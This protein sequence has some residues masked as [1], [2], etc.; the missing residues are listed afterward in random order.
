MGFYFNDEEA[1]NVSVVCWKRNH[2]TNPVEADL[3]AV[4]TRATHLSTVAIEN[5]P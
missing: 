1:G 3:Q 4:A 2:W 5:S